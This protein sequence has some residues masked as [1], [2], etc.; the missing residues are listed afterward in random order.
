MPFAI[1]AYFRSEFGNFRRQTQGQY[2]S[3]TFRVPTLSTLKYISEFQFAFI[4][5]LLSWCSEMTLESRWETEREWLSSKMS[6]RHDTLVE[7]LWNET[8]N[9]GNEDIGR[10]LMTLNF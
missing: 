2:L 4:M 1:D 6:G 9:S 3:L 5:L 8:N 7:S 10:V